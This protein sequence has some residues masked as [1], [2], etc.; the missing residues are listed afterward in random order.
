LE[1]HQSLFESHANLT[2][3]AESKQWLAE[4]KSLWK[5][6]HSL[7]SFATA[8]NPNITEK[9]WRTQ[10]REFGEKFVGVYSSSD[11][12]TYIHVFVYHLGY[13]LEKHNGV[14]KLG[15]FGIE[16]MHSSK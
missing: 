14:E 15:K 5:Q 6:F 4:N 16:S 7:H 3:T 12:T 1:N 11:V 2:V 9:D 10:A 13:F 8:A